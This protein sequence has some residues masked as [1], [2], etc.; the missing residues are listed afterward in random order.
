M[1]PRAHLRCIP[2]LAVGLIVAGCSSYEVRDAYVPAAGAAAALRFEQDQ[3][4][5]N[6]GFEPDS[7]FT[8]IGLLGVPFIPVHTSHDGSKKID[9]ELYLT[10][11]R[12]RDFSFTQRPCLTLEGQQ[13][14][15]PNQIWLSASALY[16]D[17][18]SAYRDQLPRWQK[19]DAFHGA[20]TELTFTPQD[21][22]VRVD[23]ARVYRHYGYSGSPAWGYMHV[24][25]RY[26]YDCSGTCPEQLTLDTADLVSLENL[27]IPSRVVRFDKKRQHDYDVAEPVQ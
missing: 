14:L 6:I 1:A 13:T 26:T 22:G 11:R 21:D 20:K 3:A 15:C 16:Q 4:M 12:D 23:R 10:L 24:V 7:R 17:D 8:S 9:L 27:S 19:L 2:L 5:L 18:G 25:V